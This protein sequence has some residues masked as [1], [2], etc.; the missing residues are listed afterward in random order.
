MRSSSVLARGKGVAFTDPSPGSRETVALAVYLIAGIVK[1]LVQV[2][3]TAQKEKVF[4]VAILSLRNLLN[5][6]ELGLASDMVEAGLPK[7]VITRQMQVRGALAPRQ[8]YLAL[9]VARLLACSLLHPLTC[10]KLF[11]QC[12]QTWG[13]EDIMEMLSFL[14]EKLKDGIRGM[15]SFD[16]YKKEVMSGSLEG[17]PMHTSDTFWKENIDKFEEKDFQVL[18]ALL[19]LIE[20][21]REVRLGF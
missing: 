2:A 19:K 8:C 13:D 18:R 11:S 12:T 6:E 5:H 4:R 3:R 14:D 21:S 17:G 10:T 9:R 15:S 7:I 16:L 20:S 1:A